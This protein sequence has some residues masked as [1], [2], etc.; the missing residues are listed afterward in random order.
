MC[1]HKQ[2]PSKGLP[3]LDRKPPR[4]EKYAHVQGTLDTG[5]TVNKIKFITN[6][7]C[8][9]RRDEIHFRLN[10]S[11]LHELLCEY[12]Q[13]ERED[14]IDAD[15]RMSGPKIVSYGETDTPQYSKPYLIYDVR[16]P[17]EYNEGHIMQARSY[18]YTMM[19]RDKIHPELYN[20]RNKDGM[21]IIIYC[22]DEILSLEAAKLLVQRGTDNVYLLTGGVF[23]F[24]VDY[25]MF[26][27]GV[28]PIPASILA[29]KGAGGGGGGG[30]ITSRTSNSESKRSVAGSVASG[31]GSSTSRGSLHGG[32]EH[33]SH[34]SALTAAR[35]SAMQAQVPVKGIG[36]SLT[37]RDSSK[38][39][40]TGRL[41]H[42][43]RR[44]DQSE[45][46]MSTVSVADSI[47]SRAA[48][49]KGKF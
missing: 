45:S 34:G 1:A 14:I 8:S 21:L 32:S 12:E 19:R 49:K 28:I 18:P 20:F 6:K 30:M 27:E 41:S 37:H 3:P 9:R 16:E 47:I 22:N 13:Q 17:G 4:S 25:S 10:K 11:H 24:G 42:A 5:P 23:E 39:P 15:S 38:I 31:R 33:G 43:S 48:A 26:I 2:K 36:S 46:G 35:L 29:K 40:A 44:D 7:E